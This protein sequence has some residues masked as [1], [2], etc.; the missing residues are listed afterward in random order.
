MEEI[1]QIGNGVYGYCPDCTMVGTIFVNFMSNI[2]TTIE[3]TV[4]V[5]VKNKFLQKKFEMG[6]LYSGAERNLGFF[7]EKSDF[8]NTE[9][10]LLFGKNEKSIRNNFAH[11]QSE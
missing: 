5:D 3:S 4:S 2:L 8:K 6:G 9:I 7:L 1:A 11:I 10:K